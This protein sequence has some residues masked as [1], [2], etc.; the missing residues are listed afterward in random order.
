MTNPHLNTR[1]IIQQT[2]KCAKTVNQSE[3]G[4]PEK[5]VTVFCD[6][7]VSLLQHKL[8]FEQWKKVKYSVRI[9]L[10]GSSEAPGCSDAPLAP[11]VT[12]RRHGPAG[13]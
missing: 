2:K 8:L 4:R 11:G 7:A 12:G 1:V 13:R 3:D 6:D 10:L 9:N 5:W